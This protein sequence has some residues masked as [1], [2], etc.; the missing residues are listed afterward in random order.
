MYKGYRTCAILPARDEAPSIAQV[1]SDLRDLKVLDRIIVC[2][3]G[4]CDGT[5][6]LAKQAGAEIISHAVPGYGGACL[7]ALSVIDETDIVIFVDADNS[8]RINEAILLLDVVARGADLAIGSR[9][10]P[11]Q[12]AG[13]MTQAQRFGNW[14]AARLIKLIWRYRVSD[15]GPFRAIR[16]DALQRIDMQDQAFGWTVEMQIKAIQNR[17]IMVEIPVHYRRR[18][19]QSKISGTLT[20]VLKAAYG[21]IG[22]IIRLAI[23]TRPSPSVPI[24]AT[25][26]GHPR[27]NWSEPAKLRARFSLL[28]S[29]DR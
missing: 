4:S 1:V 28:P 11:W 16:F 5:G 14:L 24:G 21:I 3:N 2:D 23:V 20:G 17:L 26:D 10:K 9:I 19:G 12:E 27:Q 7:K 18:M 25:A 13:S 22:T 15:L 29:R 6:L 8:L